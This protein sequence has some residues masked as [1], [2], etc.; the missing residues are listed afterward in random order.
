MVKSIPT[1]KSTL[2]PSAQTSTSDPTGSFRIPIEQLKRVQLLIDVQF[3]AYSKA[4]SGITP[5][6]FSEDDNK[7]NLLDVLNYFNK[8]SWRLNLGD[9]DRQTLEDFLTKI[10]SELKEWVRLGKDEST[11]EELNN[12]EERI[13]GRIRQA[14][15]WLDKFCKSLP[16]DSVDNTDNKNVIVLDGIRP[17][18]TVATQFYDVI[19][20]MFNLRVAVD[21]CG[22]EANNEPELKT[23]A[24]SNIWPSEKFKDDYKKLMTN[25]ETDLPYIWDNIKD[26]HNELFPN[27]EKLPECFRHI[28]EE[29]NTLKYVMDDI[30][31]GVRVLW[32]IFVTN[33]KNP[34]QS[35]RSPT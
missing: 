9:D 19:E 21:N 25:F 26:I 16:S 33:L 20:S 1:S 34:D 6:E 27:L 3:P 29:K 8:N 24:R 12:L 32:E 14:I 18:R 7:G 35:N 17:T 10:P 31:K 5:R 30:L 13:Y 15:S 4:E 2:S 28:I 22:L 23:I 11:K